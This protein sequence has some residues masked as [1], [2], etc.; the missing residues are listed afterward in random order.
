[1][2]ARQGA[3]L[4]ASLTAFLKLSRALAAKTFRKH[5]KS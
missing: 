5:V 4:V 3:L 1:M 2:G